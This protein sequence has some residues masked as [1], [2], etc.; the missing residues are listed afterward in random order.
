MQIP[1]HFQ[2]QYSE[3]QIASRIKELGADISVWCQSVWEQSHTDIIA[4]PVLRGGLFFF[5]DLVRKLDYSV[6]IAP[7]QSWG[8][9]LAPG[10]QRSKIDIAID[11]VPARGRSVLIVD[12]ICDSGRT[13][14]ALSKGLLEKGAHEVKS[15]VLIKREL[16]EETFDP[17]WVG[18]SYT[19]EEWFVG[20]GM[21]DTERFRNLPAV[22]LIK[23][24]NE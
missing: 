8:Y 9:E 3:E 19:G 24:P 7:A 17:N 22:H 15:V 1:K 6:E 12:D 20:Y 10:D 11:K 13:L 2:L 14:A 21:E 16:E 23:K 4:I 18:F 5:A